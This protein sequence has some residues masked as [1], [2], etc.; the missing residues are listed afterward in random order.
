MK[1]AIVTHVLAHYRR[2]LFRLLDQQEDFEFVHYSVPSSERGIKTMDPNELDAFV[3]VGSRK[4]GPMLWHKGV[5]RGALSREFDAYIFMGDA[6]HLSTWLA[7]ALARAQGKKVYFWT[8]GWHRPE[9][10]IKRL[11]RL[12]FYRLAH[13]LMVYGDPEKTQAVEHGYPEERIDVVY[14]SVVDLDEVDNHYKPS[15]NKPAVVGALIRLNPVKKLG[16]LIEAVA[17]LNSE[18]HQ[19][20]VLLGGE[21]PERGFLE[22]LAHRLG[23]NCEFTGAIYEPDAVAE[24]YR[25][26]LITVVP[27][28]AGLTT[29]QSMAH[30]VPVI[31]DNSR[32]AQA[33][34]A[35]AILT[36]KTGDHFETGSVRALAA[37]IATWLDRMETAG[38]CVSESCRDEVRKRWSPEVQAERMIQ[39]LRR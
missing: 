38:L 2:N 34:E 29:I 1:V 23:V 17:L 9:S 39:S 13:R 26:L 8:I 31:T 30:G 16:L 10:G 14:N 11:V 22:A 6:G 24:F 18:G 3:E 36:G 15:A 7:A 32:T 19:V 4:I 35:S 28:T 27:S 37:T 21:G 5:V 25:R 20:K 33:P 12:A